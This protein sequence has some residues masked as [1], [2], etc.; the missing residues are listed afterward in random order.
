[1][2]KHLLTILTASAAL[3]STAVLATN[4]PVYQPSL[5]QIQSAAA[6]VD[7]VNPNTDGEYS[8]YFAAYSNNG[9]SGAG[10]YPAVNDK[11]QFVANHAVNA[12]N[13]GSEI[14]RVKWTTYDDGQS[15][16]VLTVGTLDRRFNVNPDVAPRQYCIVT[17]HGLIPLSH[18]VQTGAAQAS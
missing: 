5:A 6:K 18:S 12:P 1:M 16:G 13:Y 9:C 10:Y 3:A 11:Y 14:T 15:F 2:K 8:Y 17:V 4:A 7:V